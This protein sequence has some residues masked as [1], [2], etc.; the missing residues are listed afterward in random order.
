MNTM[1]QN[2]QTT[3]YTDASFDAETG[4]G[5]WACALMLPNGNLQKYSGVV[6]ILSSGVANSGDMECYAA[7]RAIEIAKSYGCLN[8]RLIT[9]NVQVFEKFPVKAPL[10]IKTVH[11][12]NL[13]SHQARSIFSWCDKESRAKMQS[14][15][16][17]LNWRN[18]D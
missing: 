13:G 17:L 14:Q 6:N 7:R 5:G 12:Q 3:V 4:A 11:I 18:Q 15:R 2:L 16:N 10:K 1:R 8:I 9:D